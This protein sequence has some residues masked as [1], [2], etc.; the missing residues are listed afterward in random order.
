MTSA[1]TKALK[2]CTCGNCPAIRAQRG[3][4]PFCQLTRP[5]T[6]PRLLLSK[7]ELQRANPG[8]GIVLVRSGMGHGAPH[9]IVRP[10]HA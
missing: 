7:E 10:R 8:A 3:L 1:A 9:Y 2:F 6:L 5:V 4:Q